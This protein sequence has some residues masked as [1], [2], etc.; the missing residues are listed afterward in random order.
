MACI[1][2]TAGAV[3]LNVQLAAALRF[4]AGGQVIDISLVFKPLSKT[5]VY[6]CIHDVVHAIYVAPSLRPKWIW[7]DPAELSKVEEGFR[8]KSKDATATRA[9]VFKGCAG[10]IDGCHLYQF[11]PSANNSARHF[12]YR[13]DHF[14]ILLMAIA[15]SDLCIRWYA[16]D[17]TST[18]H[19]SLAFKCTKLG[20]QIYEGCGLPR[21][22]FF[23]GDSAF[24]QND[25]MLGP[26]SAGGEKSDAWGW[27]QSSNRMPVEQAFGVLIRTWGV[28]WRPL[29]AKYERPRPLLRPN[30]H[31]PWNIFC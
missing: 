30:G 13:K 31:M 2:R 8:A 14:T 20:H 23:S 10:A 1:S 7:D 15:D 29:Q 11:K 3:C 9:S 24:L 19:D 18:T 22:F 28:L 27:L 12:C 4:L 21:P 17:K 16:M 25:F 5:R 6:Q 26:S